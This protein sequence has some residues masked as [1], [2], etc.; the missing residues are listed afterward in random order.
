MRLRGRSGG[1]SALC[2]L[3]RGVCHAQKAADEAVQAEKKSEEGPKSR[4][5][6]PMLFAASASSEVYLVGGN[7]HVRRASL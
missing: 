3:P 4:K 6:R 5:N 1:E 7:P 2:R